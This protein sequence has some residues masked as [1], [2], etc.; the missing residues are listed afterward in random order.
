MTTRERFGTRRDLL[1]L[2]GATAVAGAFANRAFADARG[3]VVV[4]GGGFGGATCSRYLRR[5]APDLDVTLVARGKSFVTCPFSNTVIGGIRGLGSVTHGYDGI[6]RSG[7]TVVHDEA[8]AIDADNNRIR[9]SGGDGLSYDRLVLSPGI[10]IKW[11]AIDGYDE[12]AA[13]RMPHAWIAGQQTRLLRDQL[14]AMED[15]GLIVMAASGQSVPVPA[16]PL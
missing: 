5:L 9:L 4:V 15:G 16:G 6:R 12:A 1:K 3:S 11:G 13:E 14:V 7:V 10:D 8:V 2:A